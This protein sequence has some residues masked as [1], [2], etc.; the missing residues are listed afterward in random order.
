MLASTR[1]THTCRLITI[2]AALVLGIFCSA[3]AADDDVPDPNPLI[4]MYP[5]AKDAGAPPAIKPGMRITYYGG[6]ASI[7]GSYK[8]TVY[9]PNGNEWKN[10]NTG[11]TLPWKNVDVPS[12][13]GDGYRVIRVNHIDDKIAVVSASDYLHDPLAKRMLPVG[14]F[15][16]ATNAGCAAD[17]WVHPK[18]LKAIEPKNDD[19]VV[20]MPMK[21][22]MGQ[23]KFDGLRF[24]VSGDKSY[25]M[26][27]YDLETGLLLLHA[28][29]AEGS[30]IPTPGI[31]RQLPPSAAPTIL[32]AGYPAALTYVD[33]PWK[34]APVPDWVGNFRS[35]SYQG[36]YTSSLTGVGSMTKQFQ[37][38]MTVKQRGQKWVRLDAKSAYFFQGV[39]AGGAQQPTVYG[40][41]SVGG[42]WIAPKVLAKLRK[43]QEIESNK[44][45]HT[46]LIVS[47]VGEGYVTI[48]EIGDA[49]RNDVT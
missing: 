8:Q 41:A 3:V 42:L 38:T 17:F 11:Q 14:G 16:V 40:S 13:S 12:A 10:T 35:L 33:L 5:G 25:T 30:A 45:T 6:S 43:G 20:I 36:A 23:K 32:S 46:K 34:D 9:D 31:V 1:T 2:S 15:G 4:L 26:K 21:L 28:A 39:P 22:Q 18:V 48:S 49:H 29:R 44:L 19:G 47:D 27:V 24:Q 37:L 7:P